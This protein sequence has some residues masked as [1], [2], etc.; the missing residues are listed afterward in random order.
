MSS[1]SC[2]L[3]RNWLF[4]FPESFLTVGC[5]AG[6]TAIPLG[7]FIVCDNTTG[8]VASAFALFLVVLFLAIWISMIYIN[9]KHEIATHDEKIKSLKPLFEL[10]EENST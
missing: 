10:L 9:K 8:Y 6:L 2:N 4:L 3:A 7:I 5:L 1:F